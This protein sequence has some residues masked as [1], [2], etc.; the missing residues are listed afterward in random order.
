MLISR[1]RTRWQA[2]GFPTEYGQGRIVSY[3][4]PTPGMLDGLVG[5]EPAAIHARAGRYC[6]DTT[7]LIGP[8]TIRAAWAAVD[9]ALT[10]VDL[11]LASA[12]IAYAITRPPGHHATRT[13]F[14]GSYYLNN[15]AVAAATLRLGNVDRVAIID[16]DTHHGNG[17]QSVFYERADVYYGSVHVDPGAGW[18]PHFVGFG[19][20]RGTGPGEGTNPQ[21]P[22][23]AGLRRRAVAGGR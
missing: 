1:S 12:P 22:D 9:A 10:A 2:A 17:T 5:H 19:D 7:T 16:I 6:Y 21:R 3:V 15:A 13:G 4:F 11:V 18:F 8:G 20:E 23:R 14:G